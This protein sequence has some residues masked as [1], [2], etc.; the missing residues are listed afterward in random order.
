MY[1]GWL[2]PVQ[3]LG[4]QEPGNGRG[5]LRFNQVTVQGRS[6]MVPPVVLY[7]DLRPLRLL[8][9]PK[10]R[11]KLKCALEGRLSRGG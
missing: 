4:L 7:V 11:Y 8:P 10:A 9:V 3:D 2:T 1:R 5:V 6:R